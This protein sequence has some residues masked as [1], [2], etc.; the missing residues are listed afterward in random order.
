[1]EFRGVHT[2]LLK[3]RQPVIRERCVFLWQN[4]MT[5][6]F[7]AFCSATGQQGRTALQSVAGSEV[8]AVADDATVVEATSFGV[9][10]ILKSIEEPGKQLHQ[11][12]VSLFGSSATC[13]VESVVT[14]RVR[15]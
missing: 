11:L 9:L 14:Q 4:D 7:D 6:V 10:R 13:L 15:A 12:L 5:P 2:S 8:A 3:Q 1:M